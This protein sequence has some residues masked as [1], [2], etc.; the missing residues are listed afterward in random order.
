MLWWTG[1]ERGGCRE[2][3]CV[4]GPSDF[5]RGEGKAIRC[6]IASGVT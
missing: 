3:A 2:T 1:N 5:S 4:L 6:F